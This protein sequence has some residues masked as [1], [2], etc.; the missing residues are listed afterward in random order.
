LLLAAFVA[1][2]LDTSPLHAQETPPESPVTL[3]V[4]NFAN[5]NPGDGWDW[6]GTGL[7]DML[8]TDLSH[9][10]RFQV[11]TRENM[12]QLVRELEIE[13]TGLPPEDTFRTLTRAARVQ[14]VVGGSFEHADGDISIV[15]Y[16]FDARSGE[17]KRVEAVS[18]VAEEVFL[19]ENRLALQLVE[20]FQVALTPEER[21]LLEFVPTDNLDAA[22]HYYDAIKMQDDGHPFDAL[23]EFRSAVRHDPNYARAG[24]AVARLY[25]QLREPLHARVQFREVGKMPD[26]NPEACDALL[27]YVRY[28]GDLEDRLSVCRE[29]MRRWP[30]LKRPNRTVPVAE[31]SAYAA[32]LLA[33]SGRTKEAIEQIRGTHYDPAYDFWIQGELALHGALKYAIESCGQT[34]VDPPSGYGIPFFLT[35]KHPS[36]EGRTLTWERN[37]TSLRF[38]LK[39]PKRDFYY[40]FQAERGYWLR[41]LT[42]EAELESDQIVLVQR[43][44]DKQRSEVSGWL[45]SGEPRFSEASRAST[46]G[47]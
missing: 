11:V 34:G 43:E 37:D 26:E 16:V 47:C 10:A 38:P 31:A 14:Y 36:Y 45:A 28:P 23:A 33:D 30:R 1:A 22:A 19:L 44:L 8:I 27:E 9:S 24:F 2:G 17:L 4:L 13:R 29:I 18:G 42:L 6:L 35:R 12:A 20:R 25:R 46:R 7:A 3:A 21:K 32:R 40:Y 41:S 5:R 39:E 15:V